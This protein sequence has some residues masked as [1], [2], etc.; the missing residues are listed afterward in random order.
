MSPSFSCFLTGVKVRITVS[1]GFC[2]DSDT[3]AQFTRAIA[4]ALQ[5]IK[6]DFGARQ[7]SDAAGEIKGRASLQHI[8]DDIAERIDLC[9]SHAALADPSRAKAN[10][11]RP[12][13]RSVAGYRL[14][15]DD[16]ASEIQDAR[17]HVAAENRAVATRDRLAIDQQ[18]MCV[19][20]AIGQAQAARFEF[21][22]QAQRVVECPPLQPPE[23]LAIGDAQRDGQASHRIDV[24]STLFARKD[25]AVELARKVTAV[26]D[27]DGAAR[28]VEGFVRGEADDIG[29]ANRIRVKARSDQA[30]NVGD[31]GQQVGADLVGDAA[32]CVPVGGVG[33]AAETADDEAWFVLASEVADLLV[34]KA[35]G[36]GVNRVADYVVIDAAA[37]HRAAMGE[38]PAH[39]QV[40]AHDG[41]AYVKQ[42]AVDS[43]VGGRARKRLNIHV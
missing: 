43:V 31:I 32:E 3:G 1:L 39:D 16:D 28:S 29:D 20:A 2:V 5:G 40:H 4:C 10:P 7:R 9:R 22:G 30:G 17:C 38:M 26:S 6:I 8:G 36:N 27:E 13:R 11:A 19:G 23:L 37:V 14:P 25:G 33:V 12:Q 41:V 15:I 24:W 18:Q 21:G 35:L 34:I 42:C